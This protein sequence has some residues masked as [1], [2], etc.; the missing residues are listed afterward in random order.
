VCVYLRYR[1]ASAIGL[2]PDDVVVKLTGN[3]GTT[4]QELRQ[5]S[6]EAPSWET[7]GLTIY[8][9]Q[10]EL[11]LQTEGGCDTQG[12]GPR[13]ARAIRLVASYNQ[14]KA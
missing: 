1:R 6:D 7:F 10:T 5:L 12:S 9:G 11:V 13:E 14:T 2:K 3:P 4:Q 8:R